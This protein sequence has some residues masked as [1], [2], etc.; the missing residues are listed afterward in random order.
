[1]MFVNRDWN[2]TE[3]DDWKHNIQPRL[4]QYSESVPVHNEGKIVGWKIQNRFE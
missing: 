4:S 1:M 2:R 3:D